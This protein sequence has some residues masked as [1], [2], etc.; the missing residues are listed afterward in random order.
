MMQPQGNY[1][2]LVPPSSRPAARNRGNRIE[3]IR[4]KARA[5]SLSTRQERR[6]DE[7]EV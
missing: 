6:P 2:I 3:Q 4:Q 5:A 7:V 1:M